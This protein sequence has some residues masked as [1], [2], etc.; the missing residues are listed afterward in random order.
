MKV[1]MKLFSPYLA[2]DF[3]DVAAVHQL[4]GNGHRDQLASVVVVFLFVAQ[5]I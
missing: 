1:C 5:L 3:I 4:R 2:G